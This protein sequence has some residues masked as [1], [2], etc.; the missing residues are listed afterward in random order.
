[1]L[2]TVARIAKGKVE[3]HWNGFYMRASRNFILPRF[4]DPV[5]LYSAR[6]PLTRVIP[7]RIDISFSKRR[8][9]RVRRGRDRDDDFIADRR[10]TGTTLDRQELR[11]RRKRGQPASATGLPFLIVAPSTVVPVWMEH[12]SAWGCFEAAQFKRQADIDVSF[13]VSGT[14]GGVRDAGERKGG[15]RMRESEIEAGTGTG[16][17]TGTFSCMGLS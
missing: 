7:P 14:R 10:L 12:L 9:F 13:I 1:M 17:G 4:W 8:P 2:S 6:R 15:E 5:V 11:R 3:T 16:T